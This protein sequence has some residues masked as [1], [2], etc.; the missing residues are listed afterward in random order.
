TLRS[1][2][3]VVGKKENTSGANG[4]VWVKTTGTNQRGEC[5]LEYFRWVMVHKRDPSTPTGA[6]DKPAMP[7]EVAPGDLVIPE[8][9]NLKGY[10]GWVGGGS[11]WEDYERGE[12]IDHVDG[13]T[14]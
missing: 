9:L 12:K 6:A 1:V 10:A 11:Y 14:I 7:K 5:V 8:T 2:S 4:I 3:E 13:M